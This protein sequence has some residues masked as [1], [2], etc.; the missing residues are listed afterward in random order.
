MCTRGSLL[1]FFSFLIS[2]I[3]AQ[4]TVRGTIL[5]TTGDTLA[6]ANIWLIGTYD[7]ATTDAGGRFSFST[8]ESGS[9][10][11]LITCLGFDTFRQ[12]LTLA[13]GVV[14]FDCAFVS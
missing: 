10:T 1:R 8:N 5:S 3:S 6:G 13:G 7:G 12:V 2:T 9:Q 11:L 14:D 4:T